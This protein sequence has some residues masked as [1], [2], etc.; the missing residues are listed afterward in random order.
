M[1]KSI[2]F[3]YSIIL[4]KIFWQSLKAGLNF[5]SRMNGTRPFQIEV[6]YY[7]R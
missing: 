1:H 6:I 7:A 2:L 5:H 3:V 4:R